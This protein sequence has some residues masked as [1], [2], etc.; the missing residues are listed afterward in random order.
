MYWTQPAEGG[1]AGQG[2][3]VNALATSLA[4]WTFPRRAFRGFS[5]VRP[6]DACAFARRALH[7]SAAG[8]AAL[9]ALSG[10]VEMRRRGLGAALTQL[11]C[12]ACAA[13]A[14][15]GAP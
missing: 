5:S 8:H 14:A 7:S 3:V 1:P 9:R 12:W 13:L 10:A 6:R 11:L 4:C 2:R 15:A